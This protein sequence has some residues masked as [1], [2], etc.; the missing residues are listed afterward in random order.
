MSLEAI[1]SQVTARGLRVLNLC[2]LDS[3]DWRAN[4]TDGSLGFDFGQGDT[5]ELALERALDAWAMGGA[6]PL[7]NGRSSSSDLKPEDLGL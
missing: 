3:G 1:I 5:P 7:I 2:Q 4:L 6:E